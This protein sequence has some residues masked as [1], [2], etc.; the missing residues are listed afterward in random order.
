MV[1]RVNQLKYRSKMIKFARSKIHGWGLYSLENIQPDEMIVE[2]IG[3]K[4]RPTVSGLFLPCPLVIISNIIDIREKKYELRGMGSS[5]MFRIDEDAVVDATMKGNF[6]RLINHSCT[7]NC[8][9]KIL[10]VD[11]DKRIVIYSKRLIQRGEE[12]TYDYKFP[13]EDEK[14]PCF[15]GT[16]RRI[17]K[18][19]ILY[20]L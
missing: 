7:P 20:I 17:F 18:C 3:E 12:I 5:Y 15:C 6:A 4:I 14:I 1:C 2:Y 13:I 8:Y 16:L 10:N 11:R 19:L 9:A